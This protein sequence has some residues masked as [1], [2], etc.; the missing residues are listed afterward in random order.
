MAKAF[1]CRTIRLRVVLSEVELQAIEDY[2]FQF[3]LPNRAGAVRALLEIGM[4]QDWK[5]QPK[6]N[7]DA[8]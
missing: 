3:R 5:G 4:A 6:P 2:R 1:K 7:T 8:N